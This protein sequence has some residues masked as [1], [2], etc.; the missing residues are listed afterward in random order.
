[1]L[2]TRSPCLNPKQ[3]ASQSYWSLMV[4]SHLAIRF[5]PGGLHFQTIRSTS[6][7]PGRYALGLEG[8]L[9]GQHLGVPLLRAQ[10][11]HQ[12]RRLIQAPSTRA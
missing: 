3:L 7:G 10:Q 8:Q 4:N 9:P 11:L 1:M 6:L 5:Q 12:R 2:F